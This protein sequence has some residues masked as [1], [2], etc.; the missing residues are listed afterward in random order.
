MIFS[1]KMVDGLVS[2]MRLLKVNGFGL[3]AKRSPSRNGLVVNRT[4]WEKRI[5]VKDMLA[6]EIGMMQAVVVK[7]MY[8]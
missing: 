6:L 3:P 8:F 1:A 5:A 4:I 7:I 2:Q